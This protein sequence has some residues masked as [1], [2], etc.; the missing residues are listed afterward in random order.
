[1]ASIIPEQLDSYAFRFL[2]D[3]PC[4]PIQLTAVGRETRVSPDYHFENLHRESCMLLQYTLSGCGAVRI[5][6]QHYPAGPGTAFLLSFPDDNAYYFDPD[7]AQ[8]WEF[9][10]ILFRGDGTLP[11]TKYILDRFG[12][13]FSLP[14]QHS[15][16]QQL[17]SLHIQAKNGQ[18]QDAFTASSKCFSLL[19]ALCSPYADHER[20]PSPLVSAAI[21]AMRANYFRDISIADLCSSLCVNQSHFSRVFVKETGVQPILYLT[22]LRLEEAV[23]LL[24]TTDLTISEISDRCGFDNSNYFSKVFRKHMGTSPRLFRQHLQDQPYSSVQL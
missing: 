24:N 2:Q 13:V 7:L 1:M 21:A 4:A 5:G 15:A 6:S 23:R 20:T 22:R 3:V 9:I 14:M 10:F 11:Y 12:P 18:L 17:I 19:C 16:A 8:S